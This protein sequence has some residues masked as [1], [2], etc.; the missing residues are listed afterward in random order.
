MNRVAQLIT[1]LFV[2][3]VILA[4]I[5]AL[6]WP[7][8]FAWFQPYIVPALGVVMFGMGITL[9]PADFKRVAEKPYQVLVGV[10]AQFLIMPLTGAALAR[11]FHLPPVLAAG[12]VLVG[13]CPGGTAS[14]VIT[15]LA[16]AD[17]AL[18]VT[19]T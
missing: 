18:A 17:V 12:L 3:W 14:N 16:K 15:F 7:A 2:V 13:A 10:V 11:L 8:G 5:A 1:S 9:T 4:G 19:L 6:A